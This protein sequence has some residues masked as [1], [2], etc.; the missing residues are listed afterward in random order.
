MGMLE[1]KSLFSLVPGGVEGHGCP[2]SVLAGGC[3]PNFLLSFVW[4]NLSVCVNFS[5]WIN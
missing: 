2:I 5:V 1:N 4:I 3:L